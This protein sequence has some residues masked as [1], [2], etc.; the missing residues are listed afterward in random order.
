MPLSYGPQKSKRFKE[1]SG[2][3]FSFNLCFRSEVWF[4]SL[5]LSWP[6]FK[7]AKNLHVCSLHFHQEDF[8]LCRPFRKVLKKDAVP[9]PD[10]LSNYH[11]IS[12]ATI[13][14]STSFVSPQFEQ[15]Y[16]SPYSPHL[17]KTSLA[18]Q[19]GKHNISINL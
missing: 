4:E 15:S 10:L 2:S 7:S 12:T 14:S 19:Y 11:D 8:E 6:L 9:K 18:K 16:L 3:Y 17:N 5:N 1:T 13:A